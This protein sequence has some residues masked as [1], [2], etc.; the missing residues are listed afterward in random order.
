MFKHYEEWLAEDHGVKAPL[1]PGSH[2]IKMEREVVEPHGQHHFTAARSVFGF[3]GLWYAAHDNCINFDEEE[4]EIVAEIGFMDDF[5]DLVPIT[6]DVFTKYVK[7]VKE[8]LEW[9]DL[10]NTIPDD[11]W[12][13]E[14]KGF[15]HDHAS[16]NRIRR[17]YG[18]VMEELP[19]EHGWEAFQSLASKDGMLCVRWLNWYESP[20]GMYSNPHPEKVASRQVMFEGVTH[21]TRSEVAAEV[22]PLEIGSI[23]AQAFLNNAGRISI[24]LVLDWDVTDIRKVYSR[25]CYSDRTPEGTLVAT[26]RRNE[27]YHQPQAKECYYAIPIRGRY[28]DYRHTEAFVG[29]RKVGAVVIYGANRED[30]ERGMKSC[31]EGELVYHLKRQQIPVFY[32]ETGEEY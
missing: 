20:P 26:R 15:D 21:Q 31:H 11:R 5:G 8:Y 4:A 29:K 3:M 28:F 30:F 27:K 19:K 12:L 32:L 18:S 10:Y 14:I 1:P 6:K 9:Y 2:T 7:A 22:F 16:E 13:L 23:Q 24:G 25:D 17:N